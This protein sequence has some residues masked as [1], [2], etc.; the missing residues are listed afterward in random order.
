[1]FRF[2]NG[3]LIII[4]VVDLDYV[5]D[6]LAMRGYELRMTREPD[7][8]WEV[9]Q[10]NGDGT[11]WVGSHGLGRIGAEFQSLDSFLCNMI[12]GP[13][14]RAADAAARA[15]NLSSAP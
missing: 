10:T 7:Q 3:D 15:D 11:L 5:S 13:L 1:M 2:Y 14:S 6:A 4:V 9:Q 8:P 12:A